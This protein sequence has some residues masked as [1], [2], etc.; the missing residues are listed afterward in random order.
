[1]ENDVRDIKKLALQNYWYISKPTK[2]EIS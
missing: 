2:G 1:M